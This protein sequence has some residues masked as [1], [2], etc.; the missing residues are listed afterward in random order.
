MVR[1]LAWTAGRL[2]RDRPG[3]LVIATEGPANGWWEAIV[4]EVN[5]DMLTLHWRD[6]PWQENVVQHRSTVALIK[7]GQ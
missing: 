4:V 2:G 3:H 5:G 7:P 6:F 1:W